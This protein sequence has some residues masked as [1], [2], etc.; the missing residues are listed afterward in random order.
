MFV[1]VTDVGQRSYEKDEFEFI[2]TYLSTTVALDR[3]H[4]VMIFIE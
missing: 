4:R 2:N 1:E 3:F